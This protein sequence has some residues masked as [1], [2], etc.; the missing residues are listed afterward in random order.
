MVMTT[1]KQRV[2]L[3][4]SVE[5]KLKLDELK[6]TGQSYDGFIQELLAQWK[7]NKETRELLN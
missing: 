3:N 4:I 7:S 5:V 6:H 1:K 2:N